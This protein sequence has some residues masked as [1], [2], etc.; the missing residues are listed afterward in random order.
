MIH[1]QTEVPQ[2]DPMSDFSLST[3]YPKQSSQA[4]TPPFPFHIPGYLLPSPLQELKPFGRHLTRL[5][6]LGGGGPGH[7]ATCL[8]PLSL[9]EFCPQ[10]VAPWLCQ[11]RGSPRSLP[12]LTPSSGGIY[13][14]VHGSLP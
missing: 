12:N 11:A 10:P 8:S 2:P 5:L 4:E 6:H 7:A 3:L 1:S 14:R 13:G 9:P